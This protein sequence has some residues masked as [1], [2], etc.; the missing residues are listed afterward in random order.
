MKKENTR[1]FMN[2]KESELSDIKE[3]SKKKIGLIA[4]EFVLSEY[5]DSWTQE[6][7]NSI[8]KERYSFKTS[9]GDSKFQ[10]KPKDSLLRGLKRES[11]ESQLS[12]NGFGMKQMRFSG[13]KEQNEERKGSSQGESFENEQK[14]SLKRMIGF[15]SIT[16]GLRKR[17]NPGESHFSVN[18]SSLIFKSRTQR[19]EETRSFLEENSNIDLRESFIEYQVNQLLEKMKPIKEEEQK[20][21]MHDEFS[22]EKQEELSKKRLEALHLAGTTR[23]TLMWMLKLNL[24]L[25]F[26]QKVQ[27]A[28]LECQLA[29]IEYEQD[30]L[31]P[32]PLFLPSFPS[33]YFYRG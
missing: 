8:E 20:F 11:E 23:E 13:S 28:Q 22:P 1:Q 4:P 31:S 19:F 9:D 15:L 24:D 21:K 12:S 33:A 29:R 18:S 2:D 16:D 10:K 7:Q 14:V 26:T 6:L 3:E 25:I 17:K 30:C 32:D 27:I 5:S